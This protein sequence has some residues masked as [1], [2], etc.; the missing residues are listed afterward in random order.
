MKLAA[1][2]PSP[3]VRSDAPPGVT[4][5]WG[6][7]N[8][9]WF[10]FNNILGWTLILAAGP[11]GV[12]FPGPGGLPL[13]LIGFAMIT[14]PGKRELTSRAL[15]GVPIN[16]E[17]RLYRWAVAILAILG[18]AGLFSWVAWL[19]GKNKDRWYLLDR[20]QWDEIIWKHAPWQLLI[21]IIYL[22]LVVL[23]WI[24]A[25]RGIEVINLGISLIPI[26]RRKARP[27]MRRRGLDLLPPRRR[28]RLTQK[29][30]A[31]DEGILEIDD[32]YHKG[33][34]RAWDRFRPWIK[35]IA[36][37]GITAGVVYLIFRLSR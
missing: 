13:F 2:T 8:W 19:I 32:R 36:G 10:L 29:G 7:R 30:A 35:Y 15:R 26:A 24:F 20:T 14:L 33:A 28:K 23:I 31:A 22:S 3:P 1:T 16:P 34:I 27:W 17:A 11:V 37:I 25:F 5:R 12:V 18:P 6:L 9:F 4:P 21:F